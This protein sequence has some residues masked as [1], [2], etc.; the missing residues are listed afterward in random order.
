[1]DSGV[2]T[3]KAQ[4]HRLTCVSPISGVHSLLGATGA[5]ADAGWAGG[6][7]L[8]ANTGKLAKAPGAKWDLRA[9]D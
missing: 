6:S 1:M 5:E 3:H 4:V 8:V 7:G 2:H 9:R